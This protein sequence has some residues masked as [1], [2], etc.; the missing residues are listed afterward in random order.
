MRDAVV[1]GPAILPDNPRQRTGMRATSLE[2]S[3]SARY[4]S[5]INNDFGR[6]AGRE[7]VGAIDFDDHVGDAELA[8]LAGQMERFPN[9]HLLRLE[10]PRVTDAAL[11]HLK[12]LKGLDTLFL[13]GTRV[14]DEGKADLRRALPGL[15][16]Q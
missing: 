11:V 2:F 15:K 8:M 5:P 13:D 16:G 10:G 1:S 6:T 7:G 12:G 3:G 14:T 4:H 9:L